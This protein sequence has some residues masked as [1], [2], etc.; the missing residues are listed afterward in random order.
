MFPKTLILHQF[1]FLWRF[2]NKVDVDHQR[3]HALSCRSCLKRDNAYSVATQSRQHVQIA[4]LLNVFV[5]FSS[6][7]ACNASLQHKP[8]ADF[9]QAHV[10]VKT[11]ST[12]DSL[13]AEIA[14]MHAMTDLDLSADTHGQ[15]SAYAS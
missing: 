8:H 13:T 9:T 1:L 2:S 14:L 4:T 12:K 15:V 3:A 6:C 5:P 11:S 10:S 7:A